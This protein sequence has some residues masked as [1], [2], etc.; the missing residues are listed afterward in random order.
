MKFGTLG[1]LN[2]KQF[3]RLIGAKKR[4]FHKMV[5]ILKGADNLKKKPR[6]MIQF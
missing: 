5:V 6:T 2:S 3:P 1:K 4:T